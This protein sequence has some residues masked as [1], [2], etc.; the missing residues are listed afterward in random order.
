MAGQNSVK[1]KLTN[2]LYIFA[3]FFLISPFGFGQ[4]AADKKIIIKTLDFDYLEG[5]ET[6]KGDCK[7][8][9]IFRQDKQDSILLIFPSGG[10]YSDVY[11]KS[12]DLKVDLHDQKSYSQEQPKINMT[13]L[14]DGEYSANIVSCGLGGACIIRLRTK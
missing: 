13:G 1:T 7:P 8:I 10:S 9:E 11:L 2:R 12:K 3:F 5:C 6:G 4:T 14:P